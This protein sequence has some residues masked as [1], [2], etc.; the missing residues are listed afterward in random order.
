M[1]KFSSKLLN[2]GE[3]Q[4]EEALVVVENQFGEDFYLELMRHGQE[5]EDRINPVI[6]KFS[7]KHNV[8]LIVN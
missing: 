3:N 4:A 2:V 8:S 5:D 7:K 1:E 6:I